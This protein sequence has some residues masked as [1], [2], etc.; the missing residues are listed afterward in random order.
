M[1]ATLAGADVAAIDQSPRARRQP[2][3]EGLYV[4]LRNAEAVLRF[5]RPGRNR[6]Y[7]VSD[8]SRDRPALWEALELQGRSCLE[9]IPGRVTWLGREANRDAPD[10]RGR[11]LS[12]ATS[13]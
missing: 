12:D 2:A 7:L 10:Q 5:V 8:D 9:I 11:I 3:L 13:R 1:S 4:V 6:L